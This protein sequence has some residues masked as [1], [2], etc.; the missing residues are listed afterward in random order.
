MTASAYKNGNFRAGAHYI[1]T[2]ER[3]QYKRSF[4]RLKALVSLRASWFF[5]EEHDA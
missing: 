1:H 2:A 4:E 5:N 3:G